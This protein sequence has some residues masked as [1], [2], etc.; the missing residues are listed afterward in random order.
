MEENA[1]RL[2][3]SELPLKNRAFSEKPMTFIDQAPKNFLAAII[4]L[5]A[6]ETGN[7]TACEHWQHKQLQNLLQHAVQ[8]SAFWRQ[9]I[10][11]KKI[12]DIDLSDLPILNRSDV[13]KQVEAEG[14]L[15]PPNG[16]IPT[17]KHSTSGSSGTPVQFFVSEMNTHYNTVRSAAQYFMEGR[18]LALNRTRFRQEP[19]SSKNGFKVKK[20]DG[21]LGAL[22]PV[23]RCG[24]NKH[25]EY[26]NPDF[27]ALCKE[28]ERDPIGYLVAQPRLI[29]TMLQHI[30]P[31]FFKR[32]GTAM[33]IPLTE[34]AGAE[35][36][37]AFSSMEIP[38]RGN[39]S[40]EEVGPIGWECAKV[41][42]SYH[43]ATSNVIVE[44][45]SD[46]PIQ[47]RN[48]GLSRVLVTHLHSYATPFIRYDLGDVA[49]V[50]KLCPCGHDGPSLSNVYGR[51][52]SLLKHADGHVSIF[53]LR[54]KELTAIAKFNEYRIRQT[55]IKNI[56]VE[57]GGR[58]SLTPEETAAFIKLIKLHAGNEFEVEI[59]AVAQIDW[60]HNIKR[61]GFYSEVL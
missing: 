33:F 44:A 4:D 9:R 42:G 39:Y 48:E 32:T 35:L 10:G 41:P 50:D 43:V 58:D 19:M 15:L 25:I 1:M 54:S 52:K 46:Q 31:A 51:A 40:S 57:I 53:F 38:T 37:Q 16:T 3:F 36:R 45:I 8:R 27:N 6:I 30:D 17:R 22:G 18:D 11:T 60:G 24:M 2:D 28:L 12:N 23:F 34:I 7:R 61:L 21:W 5:V 13:V 20:E 29:E 59:K 47:L 26:F 14:S 56:V 49:T 55:D